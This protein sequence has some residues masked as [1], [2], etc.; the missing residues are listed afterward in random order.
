[1]NYLEASTKNL[2]TLSQEKVSFKKALLEWAFT[3]IVK[4][5]SDEFVSCQLC[6][7]PRLRYHF[8]IQN[9][10]TCDVLQVGSSCIK[11]FDITVYGEDG[12]TLHG[13]D[14]S[15][16]LDAEIAAKKKEMMLIP[17]RELYKAK[18]GDDVAREE[19]KF[20]VDGFKRRGGFTAAYLLYLFQQ[21]QEHT[22][23]YIPHIYKIILRSDAD[24]DELFR[25]SE[26][27]QELVWPSLSPAQK[28]RYAGQK[29]DYEKRQE[30]EA[31][32]RKME[33]LEAERRQ[34]WEA[35]RQEMERQQHHSLQGRRANPNSL[36]TG[37]RETVSPSI[38]DRPIKYN[39]K[40]HRFKITFFDARNQPLK[41]IFRGNLEE[42]RTYVEGQIKAIPAC[43]KVEIRITETSELVDTFSKDTG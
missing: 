13:E 33:K 34:I 10:H 30:R 16:R 11:K 29:E 32:R 41:R 19:I 5:Y 24:K 20:H 28:K 4:V 9:Q 17:L 23:E 36:H 7:H 21:M 42:S 38:L 14:K 18:K 25:M 8:E 15:K 43:V 35:K 39:E 1:M 2:L 22:I 3:G 12:T 26:A 27:E 37:Q 6:E 31:K 40:A